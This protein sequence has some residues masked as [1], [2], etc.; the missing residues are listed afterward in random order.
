MFLKCTMR[1]QVIFIE[2]ICNISSPGRS[3]LEYNHR[4]SH[5]YWNRLRWIF[6]IKTEQFFVKLPTH[7]E[8]VL[9]NTGSFFRHLFS[10]LEDGT[11]QQQQHGSK[12]SALCKND[13]HTWLFESFLSLFE[14]F[15]KFRFRTCGVIS[16]F[17]W[18]FFW[19]YDWIWNT[20]NQS[21]FKNPV[22]TNWFFT[23]W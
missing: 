14:K 6:R 1:K 11:S 8:L 9:D 5:K 13:I 10:V 23:E 20:K 12:I 17:F 18:S 4:Q 19:Y 15:Y 21:D 3:S 2:L 22:S 7:M 16:R